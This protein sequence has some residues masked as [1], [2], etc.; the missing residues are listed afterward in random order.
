MAH[1]LRAA[2]SRIVQANAD[3]VKRAL[4]EG[5]PEAFVDRLV[6]NEARLEALSKAVEAVATMKD[7]VGE[8]VDAWK[9]PNGL[10][11]EKVRLPLGVLLLIY[12]SRPNVTADA[13]ALCLKSGNAVLLRGGSES[14]ATNVELAAALQDGLSEAGLPPSSVTLVSRTDRDTMVALLKQEGKIDLCI[15][16]GGEG[17]I[18]F[19]SQHARIPVVKHYKGV[20]HVFVHEEANLDMATRIVVNAKASRPGVCNAAEC[21]LVDE[22]I[23]D[24]FLPKV[25]QAL[26]EAQVELRGCPATLLH[27]RR[28]QIPAVLA[29]PGDF[30][31]EFLGPI[32]AIRVVSG[33]EHALSHISRF[34]SEH[35]EAIVTQNPK[36]ARRFT[37][38]VNASAVVVNA[39]TRF[40]DGGELG[41]GAEIGISTSRLHAFGPMGLRELTSSKYV[42]YGEGQVR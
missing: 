28:A 34:G 39:S 1:A 10:E 23:A 2:A 13:A 7:P 29:T 17:L 22:A 9:R 27:L 35:T 11:V 33:L 42:L 24:A 26:V 6:L 14:L 38:E 41:L 18:D 21:L 4:A 25:G 8:V 30:G 19:V 5:R 20:C 36:V 16:R 3:D 37:R 15:P 32:L 12:E 31:R 40:N